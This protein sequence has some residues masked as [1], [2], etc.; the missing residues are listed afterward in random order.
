MSLSSQL[1]ADLADD[2]YDAKRKLGVR[3]AGKEE[4]FTLDGVQ[5]KVLEQYDNP[6]TGY[7]G[8]I[9]QRVDTGEIIVAHRGT[10]LDREKIKDAVYTDGGMVWKR[11]NQQLPEA[12]ALTQ[13]A[14][15]R[16]EEIGKESGNTPQVTTTG[17]SLGGCLAQITAYRYGL[18]GEA[19]NPYGAVSLNYDV[20]EGGHNFVNHV[21]ATDPVSAASAHYGEVKVYARE[22]DIMAL[23]TAGYGRFN[24]LPDQPVTLT[25]A[26]LSVMKS[27]NMHNFLNVDGKDN[28]DVSVLLDPRAQTLARDNQSAISGYRSD[29]ASARAGITAAS[30]VPRTVNRAIDALTDNEPKAPVREPARSTGL[31]EDSWLQRNLHGQD[32]SRQPAPG[33][34][35]MP[36]AMRPAMVPLQAAATAASAAPQPNSGHYQ[37]GA[38]VPSLRND[39]QRYVDQLLNAVRQGDN[40]RMDEMLKASSADP[41]AQQMQRQAVAAVDRDE[42]LSAELAR[43]A[44]QQQELQRQQAQVGHGRS[45]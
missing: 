45:M 6:K 24:L 43:Q 37:P 26:A 21:I 11:S 36:D 17:H 19:F 15:A 39:S 25:V 12:M 18:Y 44:E 23:W 35:W 10:E 32:F 8:T 40:Q 3:E 4:K 20:P 33:Q 31:T 1:Y 13:R 41:F 22:E 9:Y 34:Q 16:A 38:P 28:K 2:C 14:M 5:F 7:Q 29:I 42:Q 30:V 27:H